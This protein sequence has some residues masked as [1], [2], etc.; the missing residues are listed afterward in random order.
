MGFVDRARARMS[1]SSRRP[2]KSGFTMPP[3]WS[4]DGA[5][6]SLASAGIT[7]NWEM[8]GGDYMDYVQSMYKDNGIIFACIAARA[9]VFCQARFLWQT[10]SKGL[11]GSFS[12]S[13][14]LNLLDTPWVN[15]TLG[16]WLH[17]MELDATLAGNSYATRVDEQGRIGADASGSDSWITRLRPDW[18]KIMIGSPVDGVKDPYHPSCRVVGYWYRPPAGGDMILRPKDVMHY[19]PLPDPAARFLGMSWLTP[20][21]KEVTGDQAMTHHKIAFLKNSATPTVAVSMDPSIDPDDFDA[22]VS[23]FRQDYEGARNAGKT[24]FVGGGADITPLSM[25]FKA[26][27][28]T[29]SQGRGETRIASAAGVHPA[30]VGLSEGLQG[31]SL[32]Q[33]N[34]QAARRLFVDGTM[35][36]LWNKAA[37]SM[38]ALFTPPSASKRLAADATGIPFLREDASA[39]VTQMSESMTGMRT[40]VEGGWEPDKVVE[41]FMN[42]DLSILIGNHTGLLSVQLQDRSRNA[43]IPQ[44]DAPL[45]DNTL[46]DGGA[47]G[48][49]PLPTPGSAAPPPKPPKTPPAASNG[50]G[51]VHKTEPYIPA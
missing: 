47:P 3:F 23:R 35:R 50:S 48:S 18:M 5:R 15:G 20:V 19:S 49:T 34:F 26:L 44:P 51:K 1:T 41:A 2:G 4:T 22:F 31:S 27:E 10:W 30:I 11:P 21:I 29:S 36:D 25:D 14:S 28:F 7:A 40:G 17:L 12:W 42:R 38:Q 39:E 8:V 13:D 45:G 9:R 33:G 46:P 43:A 16:E 6:V 32:N 37:P 24:L